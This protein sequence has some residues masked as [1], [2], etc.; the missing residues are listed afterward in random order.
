MNSWTDLAKELAL[1]KLNQRTAPLLVDEDQAWTVEQLLALELTPEPFWVADSLQTILGSASVAKQLA[2]I[3]QSWMRRKVPVLFSPFWSESQRHL[4]W[5]SLLSSFSSSAP[6]EELASMLFT[7][8]STGAPKAIGHSFGNHLSAAQ[9][10]HEILPFAQG[11][12][13]L[14]SL[15][16]FHIG[17][18]QLVF[19]ALLNG[20]TL[21]S[22]AGR[23]SEGIVHHR[24]SHISL[25][26]R[27]L[28]DILQDES[29][30]H[31]AKKAEVILVGGGPLFPT[32][33]Q[34][35]QK[36]GLKF[37]V[38]Y[39]S[40]ETCAQ[41]MTARPDAPTELCCLLPNRELKIAEGGAV[42][43][44]GPQIA[45]AQWVHGK[46]ESLLDEK[47]WFVSQDRGVLHADGRLEMLGRLDLQFISGG[48][49]VQPETTESALCSF[50]E[51]AFAV[52]VPVPDA[53]FGARPFAFL[54][55]EDGQRMPETA[56]IRERLKS[57]V[58]RHELPV[59]TASMPKF[60][61]KVER[62]KL[63]RLAI[64]LYSTS[65]T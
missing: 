52:V 29:A 38:T 39:G 43:I 17:G 58:A 61:L 8:G 37:R 27:Q 51:V 6:H 16:F 20:G 64:S 11:S 23:I 36:H 2:A 30:T 63:R 41:V 3:L 18:L 19:R 49:N 59:G 14:V 28:Q 24:P 31:A 35:A 9:S 60:S 40:T 21:V 62:R 42:C 45:E 4:N 33:A 10:S 54:S 65:N 22:H 26:D 47:G 15:P 7:S 12:T 44:R 55:L 53:K 5:K 50:P 57:S 1:N 34:A 25:V 56:E 13:W 46:R 48:E 32:T